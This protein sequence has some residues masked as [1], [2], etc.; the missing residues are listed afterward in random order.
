MATSASDATVQLRADIS[1]FKQQI[2]VAQR[3]ISVAT[4]EFKKAAAGM[5]DWS[6]SEEGL[7]KKLEQLQSTL[8]QQRKIVALAKEE[9]KKTT[10]AYG[11]NS[12]EADRARIKLNG[13]EAA[14]AKTE[15]EFRDYSSQLEDVTKETEDFADAQDD[16]GKEAQDTG[17]KVE[18]AS[19]GFTIMKGALADLVSEGIKLAIKGLKDLAKAAGEAYKEFDDGYDKVIKATGATGEMAKALEESY[20]TVA[21]SINGDMGDIGSALGEVNTRFGFTGQEL[22]GATEQ[23]LKFADITG[24]D[25]TEAVRLV[26]RALENAGMD[27]SEYTN[28]LDILAKAGQTTG[29]DISSL[30]ENVTKLGAPMRQLGFT[31]EESIALFAQFEKSGVNTEAALAGLKKAVAQWGKEGKNAKEE[32]EKA[33]DEISRAP[34]VTSAS[35][36]AIEAFGT[37]AGPE[38]AEAIQGGKLE[39]KDFL[40]VLKDSTGTV[41]AT[42][43]Q[44][45]DGFDK[46]NL[47]IQGGRVE[48]GQ[49][50]K[51]LATEHQDKII[52][53]IDNIK[54][55]IKNFIS[56]V[57]KNGDVIIEVIKS[58]IKIAATIWAVKKISAFASAINGAIS[59]VKGLVM[60]M[61][62]VETATSAANA[63]T[64]ILSS[65]VSPGGAIALGIAAIA[66]V[67]VAWISATKEEA[68]QIDVLTE[69][70]HESVQKSYE[71]KQAYDEMEDARQNSMKAVDGEFDHY[72][73]LLKEFDSIVGGNGKVKEGYEERAQFIMTT[74]N[75]AL[76]MEMQMQ[77]GIIQNYAKERQEINKL[78]ETKKAEAILQANEQAYTEAIQ[79][80]TEAA[81][82]YAK[83][84]QT[85]NDV[86]ARAEE[87]AVKVNKANIE[88]ANILK[89]EGIEAAQDYM[90][91][92]KDVFDTYDQLKL[93]VS[94]TRS[95][96][97]SAT[98]AYQG[99]NS[100][101]ENYEGLSASI[102]GGDSKKIQESLLKLESGMKNHTS[103]T[104]D[105]LEKQM[106][107]MD[108]NYKALKK[109]MEDGDTTITQQ[110]VDDAKKMADM[111]TSEYLQAGKNGVAGYAKGLKD[112]AKYADQAA[113]ELGYS[114]YDAFLASLDENSPSKKTYKSGEYFAEGFINGMDNK[115][116]AVYKK[117][118]ALARTAI[119]ALKE[120]QKEGSPSKV[121]YQSGKYFVEG[122]MNGIASMS[123]AIVKSVKGMVFDVLRASL[124]YTSG[125]YQT[126]GES[127]AEGFTEGFSKKI[128]YTMSKI[129]Y[130][131]EA[132]LKEFD[133]E[134]SRINDEQDKWEKALDKQ[135]SAKEKELEKE[136]DAKLKELDK[137]YD[138]EKNKKR[139][140]ELKAEIEAL[141]EQNKEEKE[142]LKER[143]KAEKEAVQKHFKAM[144][145]AQNKSKSAYQAA[146]QEMISGLTSALNSYQQKASDL[147]NS[148]INGIS[149][150]YQTRYDALIEKQNSLIDKLK[151]A[152]SLF[153][154]SD[155]GVM[156]IN[157][158]KQQTKQIREYADK[159]Q[160]IKSKVSSE[161]FDEIAELDMKEGGAYIDRL[162]HMSE[163][164]LKAYNEAY[165]EKAKAI[166]KASESLYKDDIE[167]TEKAYEEE[168]KSAFGKLPA[169]LEELGTEALKGFL[170]GLTSDTDY[171]DEEIRTFISA[172]V[173]QFKEE[174]DIHS[175]SKLMEKLGG[176]TGT[177]FVDGFKDKI[178]DIRKA[179]QE[180]AQSASVPLNTS[181]YGSG[182]SRGYNNA[183]YGGITNNYN[184]IQ[185]NT[186]PKSLSA[187][188]TFKARRR[189]IALVKAL[190]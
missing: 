51:D 106:K 177:G 16:A 154:I 57:V 33:L 46:I 3:Q 2:K 187:L 94:D 190:T 36:K 101:I 107:N 18:K 174:L 171:M 115:E 30:A 20:A 146:S 138:K 131:N 116:S 91:T 128:S 69:A 6:K 120:A 89:N 113:A 164:D 13:Y 95:A 161:L 4:S 9:L 52:K 35:E 23:F 97:K 142:A 189:Q 76:G 74:L 188:D 126:A 82:T 127:A 50:V 166:Q 58:I 49:Y 102:I 47:A 117:A 148:T 93:E 59:M 42:Y 125:D 160:R 140:E 150:K 157:D 163:G 75:E 165:D 180:M 179:A 41:T 8:V 1:D 109:Q 168:L 84:Q 34:D 123:G 98:E 38:L 80:K 175:P 62:G 104:K 96:L 15:K 88:Y 73:E 12:A 99:Y 25:A 183:Q 149:E 112:D 135:Q 39:Y 60:A 143:F 21:K 108:A 144:V 5:D 85:F 114:S 56:W 45:Q 43:E 64:G 169:Q 40:D 147:I 71:M 78:L 70:E 19:D 48:L 172:M 77:D 92:Q 79:K 173:D 119:N 129:S 27:A 31:T 139:K 11:E 121:T 152:G 66:A 44:T 32:F 100:V 65:L 22:E 159:L 155:A 87:Q 81:T 72:Q 132:K 185:N 184:L 182:I 67:T 158:I 10:E 170:S 186:S 53:V 124:K 145:D 153:D 176:F 130:Q 118:Y 137:K 86:L 7:R 181:N 110:M 68:K 54:S 136:Q 63:A 55:G 141:K 28:L 37:K 151:S 111:A 17:K 103:A 29:V 122:Y 61:K 24:V 14:L 156:T 105:E 162:L 134:I 83:A 90:Y 178:V 133:T 167:A 26:S